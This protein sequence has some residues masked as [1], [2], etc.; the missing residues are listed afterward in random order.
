MMF[1]YHMNMII[2]IIIQSAL[3]VGVSAT[4]SLDVEAF[5]KPII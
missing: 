5:Y 4:V 2:N 3:K 1:Y